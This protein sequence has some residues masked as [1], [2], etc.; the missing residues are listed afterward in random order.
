MNKKYIRL[1]VTGSELSHITHFGLNRR[2]NYR[3]WRNYKQTPVSRFLCKNVDAICSIQAVV[4][5]GSPLE[6]LLVRSNNYRGPVQAVDS[7][8]EARSYLHS[9]YDAS[10]LSSAGAA[11]H[12]AA[13]VTMSDAS[14]V[15]P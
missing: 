11:D 4:L 14:F 10:F 5:R 13:K 12:L 3:D 2:N 7:M 8:D 6:F 1:I 9:N 15:V